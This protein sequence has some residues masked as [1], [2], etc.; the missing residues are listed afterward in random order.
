LG[1]PGRP[2]AMGMSL[3]FLGWLIARRGTAAKHWLAAG[4][5]EGM[6]AA[7]SLASGVFIGLLILLRRNRLRNVALWMAA[8]AAV[9]LPIMLILDWQT[10]HSA[11]SGTGTTA[12]AAASRSWTWLVEAF[13]FGRTAGWAEI[14]MLVPIAVAGWKQRPLWLA[15]VAV[16]LAIPLLF[17]R[18]FY[19][20]WIMAPAILAIAMIVIERSPWRW[21]ALLAL[22]IYLFAISRVV[23]L[24]AAMATL[25]ADQ[26]VDAN[27]PLIRSIIPKTST[28]MTYDY[29]PALAAEYR[30]YS[31]D[32]RP[33]WR[34]VDY[35]VLTGN[36][37]GTPGKR[38]LLPEDRE[39]HAQRE[40][41]VVADRLNRTPFHLGP[42]HTHSAYG[43]GPLI[44]RRIRQ[45]GESNESA[46]VST[47][48][49]P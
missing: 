13:Q 3:G 36:G 7:T 23:L 47:A 33:D 45:P 41:T 38:Q 39:L 46:N 2:E 21:P 34:T 24:H 1:N 27:L 22:P 5:L 6:A 29:W 43:F 35:I 10:L 37:S 26:R 32:A 20:I 28:I 9:F 25:P 48:C 17:P 18:E 42:I 30:L 44:L 19:Y 40:Y 15:P 16:Q 14:A 11:S 49:Y 4:V 8:A 31:T 12:A